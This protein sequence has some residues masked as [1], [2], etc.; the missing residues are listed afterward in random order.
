MSGSGRGH[1]V[2]QV[3]EEEGA[4][5]ENPEDFYVEAVGKSSKCN[6]CGKA[7]H[8]ARECSTDMSKVKCF[9]CD[10]MGHV[11]PKGW[12]VKGGIPQTACWRFGCGEA[13]QT[14]KHDNWGH[15]KND[16]RS[17]ARKK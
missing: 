15:P 4:E 6:K 1:G 17:R 7:G 13:R 11:T 14:L 16:S 2:F 3:Q 8:F 12:D 5:E 10:Q 9:K